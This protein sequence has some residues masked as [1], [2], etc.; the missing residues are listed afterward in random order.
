[1]SIIDYIHY[2]N[3]WNSLMKMEIPEQIV[4]QNIERKK[5]T[6]KYNMIKL[7]SPKLAKGET[8]LCT[9]SFIQNIC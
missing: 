3:Q 6:V 7:I 4:M 2:V 1:M 9:H 8:S 5:P